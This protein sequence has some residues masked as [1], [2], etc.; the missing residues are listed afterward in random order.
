MRSLHD[1]RRQL[2]RL[3]REIA[4]RDRE[5]AGYAADPIGYAT[6]VLHLTLWE[7]LEEIARLLLTP[8]YRVLVKAAHGVGKTFLAAMLTG[9]WYDSFDPGLVLTTA[10]TDRQVRDLLWKEVRVQRRR[11]GLGGFRGPMMPRLESSPDH[12]A[13]GFTATDAEAFQGHH[14]PHILTV[15]DEAVGVNPVFWETAETMFGGAGH[16][17]LAIFNPT[18]QSSQAY[19]EERKGTW[20]VVTLSALDHPNIAAELAG[21]SPPVPSAIRLARLSELI[22]AWSTPLAAGEQPAAGDVEWPPESGQFVRPGP[23]MEARLLGRWPSQAINSVWSEAA[24]DRAEKLVLP[25]PARALPEYG[26]DVARYGD[27][28][29]VI[30]GRTG[31]VSHHHESHSG[32]SVPQ[33]ATRLRALA[34]ADA[35]RLGVAPKR[36]RVKIDVGGVGGGVVD[37][38]GEEYSF[39]PINSSEVAL[40]ED[41]FPNKRSE[42]WFAVAELGGAGRLSFARLPSKIRE[43]LRRQALAPTY[44]IDRHGRRVVEPKDETKK[45]LKRSPDDMDGVNLAYAATPPRGERVAGR[46]GGE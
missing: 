18:D 11:A 14:S 44:Q 8:P 16:A 40:D 6:K 32:W 4:E 19:I 1:L 13:H 23:V 7:R 37:L 46:I 39:I 35:V 45:R 24:W 25:W 34:K 3:K 41:S 33:T 38:G 28:L 9:W 26:C 15:F 43:E 42:L 29:T 10:P 36:I 27:D 21:R 17:W 31:P 20:H 2:R 30:H 22:T 5:R 12:F